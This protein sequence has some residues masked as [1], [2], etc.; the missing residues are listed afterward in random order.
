MKKGYANKCWYCGAEDMEYKG[1]YSQC[2]SCDATWTPLP[3][4]GIEA[5]DDK[6][7]IIRNQKGDRIVKTGKPSGRLASH[8][9]KERKAALPD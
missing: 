8:I 4:L 1:G 6:G 3:K 2:R 9:T 7:Q 5:L